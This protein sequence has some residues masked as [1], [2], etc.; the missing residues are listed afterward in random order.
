MSAAAPAAK[1]AVSYFRLAGMNY[2]DYISL[3]STALRRVL[4]EPQRSEA[5]SRSNFKFREFTYAA[6]G[7][8]SVPSECL[9]GR[10][11][12]KEKRA[13]ATCT[14]ERKRDG[15]DERPLWRQPLFRPPG[16]RGAAARRPRAFARRPRR[17][18]ARC[19]CICTTPRWRAPR[20]CR[21]ARTSGTNGKGQSHGLSLARPSLTL[22][23]F[24]FLSLFFAAEFYSD[25]AMA[26]KK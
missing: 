16:F 7:K 3:S 26:P 9:R 10:K 11:G 8:E 24:L 22:L 14:R 15:D 4:K 12:G 1:K 20:A 2:L 18:V 19:A 23:L 21:G 17:N 13:R 6:D 25:P 5:L